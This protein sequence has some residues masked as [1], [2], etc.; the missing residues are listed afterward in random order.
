MSAMD[1]YGNPEVGNVEY[2]GP[3]SEPSPLGVAVVP[4]AIYAGVV[5][6]AAAVINYAVLVNVGAAVNGVA[7][8]N[9]AVAK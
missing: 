8:V 7:A 3:G 4:V 6:S 5:W 1:D 2:D 9:A